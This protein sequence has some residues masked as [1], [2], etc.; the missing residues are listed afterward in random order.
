[1]TV[2]RRHFLSTTRSK[3]LLPVEK[4]ITKIV[5]R[6]PYGGWHEQ[7][8]TT[9]TVFIDKHYPPEF[10]KMVLQHEIIEHYFMHRRLSLLQGTHP[11]A[12]CK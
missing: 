11:F 2:L 8:S 10:R 4:I 12:P 5:D 6:E 9:L 1:M 7:D 3:K